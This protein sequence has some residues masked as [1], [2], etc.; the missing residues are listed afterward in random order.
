MDVNFK[1]QYPGQEVR[2]VC[3]PEMVCS[4][5]RQHFECSYQFRHAGRRRQHIPVQL[6]PVFPRIFLGSGTGMKL[7]SPVS[8]NQIQQSSVLPQISI[9]EMLG[10]WQH[11]QRK[12]QTGSKPAS[13]RRLF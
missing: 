3:L 8:K 10:L 1:W 6:E 2:G 13:I 9:P 11:F 4:S 12:P 7:E 5:Q